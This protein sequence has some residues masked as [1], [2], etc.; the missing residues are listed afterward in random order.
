MSARAY[1]VNLRIYI[2]IILLICIVGGLC[3]WIFSPAVSYIRYGSMS[4]SGLWDAV[5][6]YDEQLISIPE[7]DRLIYQAAEGEMVSQGQEVASL[8]KKGYVVSAV[9]DLWELQKSIVSAQENETIKDIYKPELVQ[10]DLD[11]EKTLKSIQDYEDGDLSYFE[12]NS[13]LIRLM[14]ERQQYIRDNF[15]PSDSVAL[16]YEDEKER[17]AALSGWQ[18]KVLAP[19]EGY[20]SWFT[21][22]LEESLSASKLS[23][24]TAS[25]IKQSLNKNT[26][27]NNRREGEVA[28]IIRPERFYIAAL[29]DN[30]TLSVGSEAEIYISGVEQAF[31]AQVYDIINERDKIIVFEISGEDDVRRALGMRSVRISIN[32]PISQGF[33]IPSGFIR[34]DENGLYVYVLDSQGK[35]KAVYINRLAEEDNQTLVSAKDGGLSL[36]GAI[37]SK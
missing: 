35:K 21:D 26:A 37:Y 2:F 23:G 29:C 30:D 27:V 9:K 34:E 31:K 1:K 25:L 16:L 10:Y 20:I 7:N 22:G 33:I 13:E 24:L 32:S 4:S 5:I 11:I 3:F 6:I 17:A 15:S 8:Y 28:K 19:A 18:E 36:N 14:E 12:L